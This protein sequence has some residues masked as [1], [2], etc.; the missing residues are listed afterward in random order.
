MPSALKTRN[1]IP[2]LAE[3]KLAYEIIYNRLTKGFNEQSLDILLKLEEELLNKNNE[4]KQKNI[5]DY[6]WKKKIILFIF[7]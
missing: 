2:T 7:K 5:K 4:L 1:K 3:E 6:F